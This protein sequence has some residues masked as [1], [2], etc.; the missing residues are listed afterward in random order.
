VAKNRHNP[1]YSVKVGREEMKKIYFL[2]LMFLVGCATY[3]QKSE[4]KTS[5][6]IIDMKLKQ[7]ISIA[8]TA[9]EV[10]K[11]AEKL[12][13]DAVN[14]SNQ[15]KANSDIALKKVDEAIKAVNE[16]R[17]FTEQEVKKAIDSA[18]K[19]SKEAIDAA[20]KASKEA[21]D[22]ANRAI[23]S[24]NKASKEAID[25]ANKASERA[26]AVAN[27]TIAEINRVR[28]T[29]QTKPEEPIIE[30]EPKAGKYYIIQKGDT[31][32]KIAYKF[33][34][35]TS[36]WELIYKSNKEIIKNPNLL[37]PGTKIYI[38]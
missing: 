14:I 1:L 33:Y 38:P 37:I 10:S 30:E 6:E 4:K 13:T 24:A 27:Q 29:I 34:S 18:N 15:A 25:A 17:K 35:D 21:I 11:N 22:A 28:A 32:K 16:A 3:Q 31:L 5:E 2:L 36:K 23:D 8:E 20:N 19:A 9:L 26:I 12:A 7:A